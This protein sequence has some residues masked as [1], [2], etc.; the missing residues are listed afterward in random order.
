MTQERNLYFCRVEHDTPLHNHHLAG[1]C[2]YFKRFDHRIFVTSLRADRLIQ[3]IAA[4]Y[5]V[6]KNVSVSVMMAS[7]EVT[8]FQ[9]DDESDGY[10]I[11]FKDKERER[12]ELIVTF[13]PVRGTCTL[14]V[15]QEDGEEVRL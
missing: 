9:Y 6:E 13:I 1:L 14:S 5:C 15:E 7:I 10:D 3:F 4:K 8:G 12:Q 11:I 2:D